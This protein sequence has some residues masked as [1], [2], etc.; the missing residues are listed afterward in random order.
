MQL[1]SKLKW[2][3]I[4][5]SNTVNIVNSLVTRLMLAYYAMTRHYTVK[6]KEH[7]SATQ[8]LNLTFIKIIF[9]NSHLKFKKNINS[10]Q[11]YPLSI[12]HFV[13]LAEPL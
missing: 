10:P 9:I 2:K 11:S 4:R 3:G 8:L 6:D 13:A 1:H 5:D 7:H 12:L